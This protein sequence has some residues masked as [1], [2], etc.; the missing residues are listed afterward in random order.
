MTETTTDFSSEARKLLAEREIERRRCKSHPAHLL[1][2]VVCLDPTDGSWFKFQLLNPKAPWYWQRGLLD[3]WLSSQYFLCLKARQLGVTWL[4]GGLALWTVLYQPGTSVLVVSINEYEAVQVINRIWNML[5]SLPKWLWN[6]A[7]VIKPTRSE[8]TSD[9]WLRF[10]DGRISKLRALASTPTAG[11]SATA[12]LVILD[13]FAR[14]EYARESWKAALPTTQKAVE[15]GAQTGKVLVISTG[16]GVSK[17]SDGGNFFHHLYKNAEDYHL[18]TRFIP[19]SQHPFRDEDW[20]RKNAESMPLADRGE[21]YPK[22]E[23]EAFI[24][25]GSPFFDQE[26]LLEYMELIPE[27]EF[28]FDFEPKGSKAKFKKW[29]HGRISV[30]AEPEDGHKYAIF[31][32]PATGRGADYSAAYVIDLA[33]PKFVCEFHA[34]LE[35]DLFAEQLHYMGRWYNTAKIAVEVAGGFGE[36]VTIP[37]RD[38][39]TARPPYP[40]LYKH[41][42]SNRPGFQE[43]KTI[44]FPTN[45]HTR[46][47]ILN[48]LEQAL[49]ERSIPF[50]TRR[51]WDECETFVR[52]PDGKAQ[53]QDG[54]NDD[55]VMAAAGA[56]EMYRLYG[57]HPEKPKRRFRS[58]SIYSPITA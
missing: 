29:S 58:R 48:Q 43:S 11:H 28:R 23:K 22:N 50:M 40:N 38:G 6:G 9:I 36:A 41:R 2:H 45:V 14:Q 31:A 19:W 15:R 26:A 49:R 42:F 13:E 44:G 56:L 30:Y 34:K 12:G 55:C 10:P 47:L 27:P 7:E 57:E 8:P 52:G 3:Q 53:A 18:K 25:T 54:C 16:N 37:L 5:Q 21:Q 4:A 1:D 20:Y 24:L 17:G 33:S 35:S 51:M 39:K 46:P 32:D